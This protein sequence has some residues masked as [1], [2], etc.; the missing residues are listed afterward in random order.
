LPTYDVAR[1]LP[2]PALCEGST[3]RMG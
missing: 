3:A 2:S 1:H